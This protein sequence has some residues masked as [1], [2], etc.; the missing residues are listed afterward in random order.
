V[1]KLVHRGLFFI[2]LA[3]LD[4]GIPGID[5]AY[6]LGSQVRGLEE[7]SVL[8]VLFIGLRE[9]VRVLAL[10]QEVLVLGIQ[11]ALLLVPGGNILPIRVYW[12]LPPLGLLIIQHVLEDIILEIWSKL[13]KEL[14]HQIQLVLLQEDQ[15]LHGPIKVL[16]PHCQEHG[17]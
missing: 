17:Q 7:D 13:G 12:R 2:R 11:I 3:L 4:L 16:V 5:E 6:L 10:G 1:G 14:S 8:F 15:S 9:L